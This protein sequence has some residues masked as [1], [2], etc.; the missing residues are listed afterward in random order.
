MSIS[1]LDDTCR[2]NIIFDVLDGIPPSLEESE[3]AVSFRKEIEHDDD[4]LQ[5][6]AEELGIHDLLLE[7]S[8]GCEL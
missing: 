7:F 8:S 2:K 1:L 3:E 6:R 4:T 5:F